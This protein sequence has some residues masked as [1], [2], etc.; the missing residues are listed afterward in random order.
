MTKCDGSPI[1]YD[2]VGNPLN[3][4]TWAYTW[5]QGRQLTRMTS[6][7][8]PNT[9][10]AFTY[11]ANGLRASRT[12]GSTTY[13]YH[14]DG[15]QLTRMMIGNTLLGFTYDASGK[16]V[17][18]YYNGSYYYY[19]LNLQ[20][21]VVAILNNSGVAVVQYTYD[22]WGRHLSISGSMAPN[23]GQLNP[24]RYRGY[25]YD[26]ETGLYYLRSR[27]YNPT[28]GRFINADDPSYL[29]VDGTVISYNLFAYCGNNPVMGYDPTGRFVIT[30][31]TVITAALIGL[32]VGA[33]AG[34]VAGAA[35]AAC[36]DTDIA[37][38]FVSGFIG[39]AIL[40]AG[41]GVGALF[42]APLAVGEGVAIG[43]AGGVTALST[44]EAVATGLTIG[45]VTGMVGGGLADL[46]NQLGNNDMRWDNVDY[47][48]VAISAVEYGALNMVSTGMGSLMG[49]YMS[50]AM[51]FLGSKMLNV[52][53]TG[54]GFV[55]DVLRN[56][57]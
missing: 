17:S 41:A 42:L 10:W 35:A 16:P 49:P 40:G 31:S 7:S 3:D 45:G 38:G 53:P 29:G 32:A 57:L 12:N 33:T 14:Y 56:Q 19:A 5:S 20:G 52:I 21:D 22:A 9:Y 36:N 11:D 1:S 25:I 48:S 47:G 44:G 55:I 30:L 37:T 8:S 43:I 18:V 27:Y 15:G 39:G 54:W 50:N 46:T 2:A 51:N 34:G 28:I 23:L 26:S 4:G 24:F 13:K 6:N